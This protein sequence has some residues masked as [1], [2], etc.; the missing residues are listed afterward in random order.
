MVFPSLLL[1][2]SRCQTL[3]A[4]PLSLTAVTGW[5]RG[6]GNARL[7]YSHIEGYKMC[8]GVRANGR[9][10]GAGRYMSLFIHLMMGENDADLRWPFHGQVIV[11]LI[12]QRSEEE[13][14]EQVVTFDDKVPNSHRN[15]VIGC[16]RARNGWGYMRFIS[17]AELACNDTRAREYLRN[18]CLKFR[19][20]K[21]VK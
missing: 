19:I 7:F 10:D 3:V 2:V 17:H 15:R 18:D 4:S 8:I 12:N 5:R 21:V 20:T 6:S 9:G 1:L 13:H 16:Q 11:Q 14:L